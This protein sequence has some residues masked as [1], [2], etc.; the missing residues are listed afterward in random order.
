MAGLDA[1]AIGAPVFARAFANWPC[2][3]QGGLISG[4]GR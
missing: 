2:A 3:W 4:S 1:M